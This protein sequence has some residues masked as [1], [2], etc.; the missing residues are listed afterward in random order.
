MAV[1]KCT[2]AGCTCLPAPGMTY[3]STHCEIVQEESVPDDVGCACGHY[4]CDPRA[5]ST[6]TEA[7]IAADMLEV[8]SRH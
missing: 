6:P 7:R 8:E 4:G 1:V 5:A 2:H 3:C